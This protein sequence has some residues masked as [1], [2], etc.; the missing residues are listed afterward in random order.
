MNTANDI[1][2][3]VVAD[4]IGSPPPVYRKL[5]EAMQDPDSSF[6]DF[7]NI[8][9]ADPSLAVRLLRIANSPFYGLGSKVETISHAL[10]VV[11]I[12]QLKELALTTILVNQFEG[13]DK[14]LVNMQSFWMHSIGCGLAARAIAKNLGE[15]QVESYYTASMLHDIGSLIIY[16]EI[17]D[18]AREILTRC[19]SEGL[20]L[21]IV[22]EEVLGFTH[23]EVGAVIFIQWGLPE[24]LVEAVRYHHRP[25]EAKEF[26]LF[27]AI[28]HLADV[29]AY[30]MKLGTGGE[31]TIP[32]L[33]PAAIKR[34]ALTRAFLT[35]IQDYVRDE[36]DE[37]IS[38]FYN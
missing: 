19:K 27:P 4:W 10:G 1:F 33:D 8:I 5:H 28:V 11:G 21:S 31:P 13:I 26:P 7:S 17:P 18:K 9:S 30:E 24:S 14:D 36:V 6:E 25:S 29:I 38:L 16:K 2:N 15:R 20:S 3:D 32:V 37:A 23:T 12:D 34:T 22:E 35:D